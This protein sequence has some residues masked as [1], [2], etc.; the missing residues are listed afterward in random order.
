MVP[1]EYCTTTQPTES[2]LSAWPQPHRTSILRLLNPTVAVLLCWVSSHANRVYLPRYRHI[3]FQLN[4]VGLIGNV[5]VAL[6]ND[7]AVNSLHF[8][9]SDRRNSHSN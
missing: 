5:F 4:S 3:C 2:Q 8:V 9:T 7:F 6:E 1:T